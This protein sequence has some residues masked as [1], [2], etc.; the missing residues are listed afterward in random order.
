VP[1][2][3]TGTVEGVAHSVRWESQG[4]SKVLRFRFDCGDGLLIPIE[5]HGDDIQGDLASGERIEITITGKDAG[6]TA[7]RLQSLRNLSTG[8][9]VEVTGKSR[10][11]RVGDFVSANAATAAIT[12]VVSGGVSLLLAK[13]STVTAGVKASPS[14]T[15]SAIPTAV[16]SATSTAASSPSPSPSSGSVTVPPVHTVVTQAWSIYLLLAVLLDAVACLV[17]YW[18]LRRLNRKGGI[19]RR[20]SVYLRSGR[21]PVIL[22]GLLAGELLTALILWLTHTTFS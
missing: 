4:N 17:L 10:A 11:D 16:V 13:A 15:P 18:L 9:S 22:A 1:D 19:K 2:E 7:I 8:F 12:T 5:L 14:P 3:L 6:A 21:T 20:P